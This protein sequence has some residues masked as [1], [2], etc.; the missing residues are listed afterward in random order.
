MQLVAHSC[1]DFL[2]S[3]TENGVPLYGYRTGETLG[4]TPYCSLE[5]SWLDSKHNAKQNKAFEIDKALDQSSQIIFLIPRPDGEKL[6]KIDVPE[7]STKEFSE[8]EFKRNDDE[9]QRIETVI[10]DKNEKRKKIDL[11]EYT[12]LTDDTYSEIICDNIVKEEKTQKEI[13]DLKEEIRLLREEL[14][15]F[16][17]LKF[18]FITLRN[19]LSNISSKNKDF[20]HDS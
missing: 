2:L 4:S 1:H 11:P 7:Y 10:R 9:H 5:F 16:D 17:F 19:Q 20:Y 18:E 6:K 15:M 8:I 14:H 12:K 3:T 13:K